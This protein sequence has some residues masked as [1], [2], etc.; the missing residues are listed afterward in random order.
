MLTHFC[1]GLHLKYKDMNKDLTI[2][3]SKLLAILV[4]NIQHVKF[5]MYILAFSMLIFEKA[6]VSKNGTPNLSDS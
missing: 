3:L 2:R 6:L 1:K 4:I 5:I